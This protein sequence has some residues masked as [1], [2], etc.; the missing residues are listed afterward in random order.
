[1]TAN[2]FAQRPL[3]SPVVTASSEAPSRDLKLR[4]MS[5]GSSIDPQGSAW[6]MAFAASRFPLSMAQE[7]GE[8][9]E[10]PTWTWAEASHC[11]TPSGSECP[12][13]P[14]NVL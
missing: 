10:V 8:M 2:F 7:R 5:Q 4:W 3:T 13:A 1:M 12:S 14:P 9:L 6:M 11:V